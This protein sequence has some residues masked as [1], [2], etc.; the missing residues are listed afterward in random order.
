MC[1]RCLILGCHCVPRVFNWSITLSNLSSVLAHM[2]CAFQRLAD[3]HGRSCIE[4]AV[5][6][7]ACGS[8][9]C[10]MRQMTRICRLGGELTLRGKRCFAASA[11][12][13][14]I[15]PANAL[16][17]PSPQAVPPDSPEDLVASTT[18]SGRRRSRGQ[19]LRGRH[20][21][22]SRCA[23]ARVQMQG[24]VVLG[25]KRHA[26]PEGSSALCC[27]LIAT[28]ISARST[29]MKQKGDSVLGK[30]H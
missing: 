6:C 23:K 26:G 12:P 25:S 2:R 29:C 11:A 3:M 14:G 4:H 21:P 30:S 24:R 18:P 27:R 20:P 16:T 10:Q 8:A 1:T 19:Q 22:S 7:A 9:A 5:P 28:W 17:L 13:R 15:P